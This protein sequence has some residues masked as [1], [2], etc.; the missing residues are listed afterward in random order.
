MI[1]VLSDAYQ[2]M[3]TEEV[4]DWIRALG[5]DCVRVNGDDL[6]APAPFRLN[7]GGGGPRLHLNVDGRAFTERDVRAVWLR[8]W[9]RGQVPQARPVPGLEPI[10]AQISGHLAAEVGAAGVG[11][12]SALEGAHWLTRPVDGAV[13]KLRVLHAAAGVGLDIPPTLVT[14]DRGEIERFRREHGRIITKSVGEIESFS[15]YGF[16]FGLYTAEVGEEDVAS[17]PTPAFPTLVQAMVEKSF[18]VRTFYLAGETH[19]MAI[20]SQADDAT[21]V[22]WRHY[23]RKKPNRSVPYRLPAEVE[24]KARRLMEGLRMETGSLDFIRA[25]DGRHVFLEVN[26]AGQFGALSHRCNYRL[27]KKVAEYLIAKGADADA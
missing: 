11:F 10:A 24:A 3:T 1:L 25:P 21:S 16:R 23:R 9:S 20:F 27:E 8:R 5:G 7:V 14:N 26:P 15:F 18:E 6:T 12:F 22:D 19:S 4:V 17:L 2:E 13:S